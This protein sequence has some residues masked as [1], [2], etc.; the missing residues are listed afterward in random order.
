[1]ANVLEPRGEVLP[2]VESDLGQKY[3]DI[4]DNLI[5]LAYAAQSQYGLRD[6]AS[7]MYP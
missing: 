1:M 3:Q 2:R 7:S 6:M 4:Q 5:D